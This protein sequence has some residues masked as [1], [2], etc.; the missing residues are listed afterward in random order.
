MKKILVVLMLLGVMTL[1]A[2]PKYRIVEVKI[3][4]VTKFIPQI[5]QK[6]Y[7]YLINQWSPL[8]NQPLLSFNE[9]KNYIIEEQNEFSR[10]SDSKVVNITKIH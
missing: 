5:K 10:K 4:G 3:E 1:Q 7:G 8:S 6:Q 9:A 2:K